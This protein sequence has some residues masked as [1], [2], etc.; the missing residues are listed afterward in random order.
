LTKLLN[1][2]LTLKQLHS[3]T[4]DECNEIGLA[5]EPTI[6]IIQAADIEVQVA[7][8]LTFYFIISQ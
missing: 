6:V 7:Y 3:L 5:E 1:E 4:K 2:W 8:R